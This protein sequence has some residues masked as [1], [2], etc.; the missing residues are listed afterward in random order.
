MVLYTDV[1]NIL[2]TNLWICRFKEGGSMSEVVA[3][4]ANHAGTACINILDNFKEHEVV[5][6]WSQL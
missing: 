1:N 5:S 3:V 6:F 4:G 2:A